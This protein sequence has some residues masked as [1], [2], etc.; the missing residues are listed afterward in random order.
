MYYC[1]ILSCI[2]IY[3]IFH[4]SIYI[5]HRFGFEVTISKILF[6]LSMLDTTIKVLFVELYITLLHSFFN[7][8]IYKNDAVRYIYLGKF[9]V[10]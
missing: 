4:Q 3:V 9:D 8:S 10:T 5:I 2:M 1:F 7:R 6:I